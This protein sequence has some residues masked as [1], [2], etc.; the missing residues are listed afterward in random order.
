MTGFILLDEIPFYELHCNIKN[1]YNN[2]N[3]LTYNK[4]NEDKNNADKKFFYTSANLVEYT[5]FNNLNISIDFSINKKKYKS[6]ASGEIIFTLNNNLYSVLF[7][8]NN[9]TETSP[10]YKIINYKDTYIQSKYYNLDIKKINNDGSVIDTIYC[11]YIDTVYNT[12][13][14]EYLLIFKFYIKDPTIIYEN[15]PGIFYWNGIRKLNDNFY[16]TCGTNIYNQGVLNIGFT[17]NYN[18]NNNYIISYPGSSIT[19]LYNVDYIGNDIYRLVGIFSTNP[20]NING[21]LYEG[22]LNEFSN[23]DNYKN[24]LIGKKYTYVHS[25]IGNV[26]IGNYNDIKNE[27]NT[28]S[29]FLYIIDVGKII[30]VVYPD[31]FTNTIY[32]IFY[33]GNNNYTI[34]GSYSNDYI[35]ITDIYFENGIRPVGNG[36]LVNY[37]ANK[38]KFSNW[39]T[40]NSFN[41]KNILTNIQSINSNKINFYQLSVNIYDM[42]TNINI[43]GWV[44]INKDSN[45][46]FIVNKW[47]DINYPY[48][49]H[50][51]NSNS[52]VDDIIVGTYVSDDGYPTAFQAK[53][54]FN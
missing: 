17:I 53:L 9:F 35:P 47:I 27:K 12:E 7:I 11:V 13:L 10:F 48:P 28:I 16:L 38:N 20:D 42:E 26:L 43:P 19:N 3:S 5:I 33:N 18:N 25:V 41:K 31:A 30:N 23:K 15:S 49:C 51:S 45:G 54:L 22:K 8:D 50:L 34:C 1:L 39:T 32:G 40:I 29:A 24:I 46:N 4:V 52:V 36:F 14:N 6:L 21:F 37:D 2:L 44:L